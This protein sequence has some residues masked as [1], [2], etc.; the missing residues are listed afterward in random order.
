MTEQSA[1]D[2]FIYMFVYLFICLMVVSIIAV[3]QRRKIGSI[4]E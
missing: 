3:L 1:K 4:S 2:E